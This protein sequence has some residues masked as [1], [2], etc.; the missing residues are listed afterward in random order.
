MKITEYKDHII[1]VFSQRD[2]DFGLPQYVQDGM[3]VFGLNISDDKLTWKID[4]RNVKRFLTLV[5][6]YQRKNQQ[7][8][9]F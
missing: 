4:K 7:L 3:F 5:D 9:L 1:A 2:K 8:S 6:R